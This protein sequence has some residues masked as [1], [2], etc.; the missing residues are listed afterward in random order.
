MDKKPKII[1]GGL[2]ID[3]RGSLHFV[4]EFNFREVKR[5][6]QVENHNK[7]VIRAFHGHF[8]EEKYA[9]VVRGVALFSLA[10]LDKKENP[11]KEVEISKF[12]LSSAAPSM[13][14]IPSGYA[15]GFKCLEENTIIMFFSTKSLNESEKGDDYRYPFD[16]WG[17]N[18]WS[19][20]NR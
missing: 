2:A 4:N 19:I 9:Y 15:N 13:L 3:D 7:D 11:S 20:E 6:Y 18:V 17:K 8:I 16:Y 10:P 1:R 5:F 14:Y 12:V